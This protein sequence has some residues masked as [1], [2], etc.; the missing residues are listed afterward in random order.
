MRGSLCGILPKRKNHKRYEKQT[1]NL[2]HKEKFKDK[3]KEQWGRTD[4]HKKTNILKT[5]KN[6][7][8]TLRALGTVL[9]TL[10]QIETGQVIAESC[11]PG[12]LTVQRSKNI[13]KKNLSQKED[14]DYERQ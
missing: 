14:H 8:R 10:E 1:L 6:I 7:R 2:S 12:S 5:I 3:T 9:G 13:D 4:P 11:P